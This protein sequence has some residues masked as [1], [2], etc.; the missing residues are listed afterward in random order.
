MADKAHM[1][2][3]EALEYH[4]YDGKAYEVGDIYAIDEQYV[5]SVA[6]QGK[7]V[8]VDRVAVAK[9]ANADARKTEAAR[10]KPAKGTAVKPMSMDA[11]P[12]V[13]P[14]KATKSA[15]AP[16]PAKPAKLKK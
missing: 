15:K 5:E 4:T 8:R 7:A 10:A 14:G 13:K 2:T 11:A 6:L 16:K 12:A 9:K 1:V 3:V